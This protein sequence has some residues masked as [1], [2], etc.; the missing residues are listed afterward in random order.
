MYL[1]YAC[2]YRYF[3]KIQMPMRCPVNLVANYTLEVFMKGSIQNST[4]QSSTSSPGRV[5]R[6]EVE[7]LME[8]AIYAYRIVASNAIGRASTT[9]YNFGKFQKTNKYISS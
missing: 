8:N 4:Q 5:V 2:Y 7:D 3:K 1:I 6:L 9:Y